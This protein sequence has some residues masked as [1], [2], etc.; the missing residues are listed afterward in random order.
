MNPSQQNDLMGQQ[1]TAR[2]SNF[3]LGLLPVPAKTVPPSLRTRSK[4]NGGIP[5]RTVLATSLTRSLHSGAPSAPETRLTVPMARTG[6]SGFAPYVSRRSTGVRFQNL[7]PKVAHQRQGAISC[8]CHPLDGSVRGRWIDGVGSGRVTQLD[9][10][11]NTMPAGLEPHMQKLVGS[12]PNCRG[13]WVVSSSISSTPTEYSKIMPSGP[14][15]YRKRAPEVGCRPGP[16]T[17]GTRCSL[18]K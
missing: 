1:G 8:D 10:L 13:R 16:N 6:L 4:I 11:E 7:S 15:K 17:I 9:V 5:S 12:K 3:K 2:A 18:R 14:V